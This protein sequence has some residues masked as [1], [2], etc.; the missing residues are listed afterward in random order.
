MFNLRDFDMNLLTVF[1]AIY[2]AGN[3]SRAAERIGLSQAATSKAL[4]RLREACGD[5]LFVRA[6]PQF[7]P[8]PIAKALFPFVQHALKM[9][10]TGLGEARGFDPAT[11][12]R[13]FKIAI[14]HPLGPFI[15]ETL[16]VSL[17]N[18]APSVTLRW[19]TKTMPPDLMPELRDGT[20]DLL[21][22]WLRVEHDQ[23]V[24]KVVLNEQAMIV[25]RRGHPRIKKAPTLE[26]VL[27][28]DMVWP[29][30]RRPRDQR[31]LAVQQIEDL[32]IWPVLQVSE[33]LEV[34]TIVAIF[35]LISI[36]PKS[37]GRILTQCMELNVFPFPAQLPDVPIFAI[38]HESRRNDVSHRWLRETVA[39]ELLRHAEQ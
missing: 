20:V 22:D 27:R 7:Q 5:E 10:R 16:R 24:N 23:F 29:H 11:S 26:E 2:E 28:E 9:V 6:G 15:A 19:D 12:E 13:Q 30:T 1:E 36:V 17:T 14:P 21:I 38:W 25:V 8:T 35:D 18:A 34:P 32:G 31:P 37:L 3:V 4:G 39:D 33:W